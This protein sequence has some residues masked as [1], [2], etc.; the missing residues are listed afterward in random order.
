MRNIG[1]V[2]SL[3]I[4]SRLDSF[5]DNKLQLKSIFHYLSM[6]YIYS[7]GVALKIRIRKVY[8]LQIPFI[9]FG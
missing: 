1:V 6:V 3:A 8:R 7:P 4:L 2:R 9:G 5:F